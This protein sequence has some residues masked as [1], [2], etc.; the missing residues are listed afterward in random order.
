M[1]P[2]SRLIETDQFAELVADSERAFLA[3]SS[4]SAKMATQA[5]TIQNKRDIWALRIE[6]RSAETRAR[7]LC[8]RA[9]VVFCMNASPCGT[10]SC[11]F[12]QGDLALLQL[13]ASLKP[14][15]DRPAGSE[16]PEYNLEDAVRPLQTLRSRKVLVSA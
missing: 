1:P 7:K 16:Y 2:R 3:D 4:Y 9:G 5:T 15:A 10:G 12:A 6:L 13:E 14:K 8:E 11:P